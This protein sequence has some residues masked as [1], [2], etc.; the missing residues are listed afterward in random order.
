VSWAFTGRGS[1]ILSQRNLNLNATSHRQN[2]SKNVPFFCALVVA[3]ESRNVFLKKRLR[4]LSS[5]EGLNDAV[6][7]LRG[8]SSADEPHSKHHGIQTAAYLYISA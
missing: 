6:L 5:V 4:F 7:R 3:R 8:I 2:S 1:Q